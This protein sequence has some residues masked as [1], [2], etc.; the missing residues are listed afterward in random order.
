MLVLP[1][2]LADYGINFTFNHTRR[3]WKRGDFPVPL[4]ISAHRIAW[5]LSDIKAWID[6]RRPSK[7]VAARAAATADAPEKP[8]PVA[9]AK[10]RRRTSPARR[11]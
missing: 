3:L 5:R 4:Q 10:L 9:S 8:A 2:Q 6:A 7:T 1:S 11:R